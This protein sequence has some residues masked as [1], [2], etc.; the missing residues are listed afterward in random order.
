MRREL[1]HLC[2]EKKQ[3][4]FLEIVNGLSLEQNMQDFAEIFKQNE[5]EVSQRT[6]AEVY[7][8]LRN[9][10]VSIRDHPFESVELIQIPVDIKKQKKQQLNI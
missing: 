9:S 10:F 8:A 4:A 7:L 2:Q 1:R 5:I 3:E 6:L